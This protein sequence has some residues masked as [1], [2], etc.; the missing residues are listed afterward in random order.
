MNEIEKR[1]RVVGICDG[2]ENKCG[3]AL[4][5]QTIG[6]IDGFDSD[7]YDVVVVTPSY[8]E[9]IRQTLAEAG[10]EE[11]RVIALE[12]ALSDCGDVKG[13]RV[14]VIFYGGLGDY[15]IGKNWL[16]HLSEYV[17]LSDAVIDAYF[18][19]NMME[20]AHA[21]FDDSELIASIKSIDTGR[22]ELVSQ[23]EYDLVLRYSI[24]PMVQYMDGHALYNSNSKLYSY[25]VRL[26][27]FGDKNYNRGF[28]AS[29]GFYNTVSALFN[30]F[31]D[32][33][34]HELYDVLDDMDDTASYHCKYEVGINE[35]EYLSSLGIIRGNF[36]T[37]NTGA[38]EE[39][40]R[41]PSTRTWPHENWISLIRLLKGAIQSDIKIVRMGLMNL[42]DDPSS[43]DIDLC[44]KTNIEQAKALL[45][46]SLVHIDYEGGLVH[47]RHVL[48]GK[49][50]V[51]LHGPTS[52]ERYGYPE[53]VAIRSDRCPKACEWSAK[54]WLVVCHNDKA[55]H[56][57]LG[58]VTPEYVSECVL[59]TL[60]KE[61][62]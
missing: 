56:S 32:K 50:S 49:P 12:D 42:G 19:N 21:V 7:D 16:Y 25:A 15:I 58:E 53:N 18:S 44:G 41:K 37:V 17:G 54:D 35:E 27:E 57:C 62:R 13:S 6:R 40:T 38:N 59:N 39:Y 8:S 11:N 52:I 28:F 1:F 47:L 24:F 29:P 51:V 48:C 34:Y 26:M 4:F 10:V 31:P 9:T 45:K 30:M 46:N 5:G 55:S 22:V 43:S 36:I 61:R 14:S 33:K 2:D 60:E 3:R 23:D 20:A